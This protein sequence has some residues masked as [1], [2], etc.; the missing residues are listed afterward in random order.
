MLVFLRNFMLGGILLVLLQ[1]CTE[2]PAPRSLNNQPLQQ[3]ASIGPS[4]LFTGSPDRKLIALG[5]DGLQL[6]EIATRQRKT[7][8]SRKPLALGWRRDGLQLAAVF[9]GDGKQGQLVL[10]DQEGRLVEQAD[11]PGVPVALAWSRHDDLL[12]AGFHLREFSFGGNLSQWLVR[13]NGAE[14]AVFELGDS[15]LKPT[16]AKTVKS[17]LAD[18][19]KVS[20]SPAGDELVVLQLHDP[21]QFPAYLQLVHRNWQV[22]KERKLLQLPVQPVAIAWGDA[23]DTVVYRSADGTVQMLP[24]WPADGEP[25]RN[26]VVIGDAPKLPEVDKGLQRFA[27]GGYLLAV[28]G[29]L[30]LG[31]GLAPRSTGDDD[32]GWTLRKWRFEGLITPEEYLEVRP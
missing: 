13:V 3:I 23:E 26:M 32:K 28:N 4:D 2:V 19:L 20:F 15:T 31:S 1:A 6:L 30:Y 10:Y 22:A 21:P 24:L 16:T 7:I 29:R 8:D 17:R 14:R 18:L 12:I 5:G 27:D 25:S 11:L 9:A